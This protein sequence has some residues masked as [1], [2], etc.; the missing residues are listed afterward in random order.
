MAKVQA[1]S[2]RLCAGCEVTWVGASDC[3]MCG[4]SGELSSDFEALFTVGLLTDRDSD[5]A[6][7]LWLAA[8]AQG[9]H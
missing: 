2:T 5:I 3:F 7:H 6:R 8:L 4:T 9:H 1:V